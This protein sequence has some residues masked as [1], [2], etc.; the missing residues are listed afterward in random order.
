VANFLRRE[1]TTSSS[2]HP[3]GSEAA[4]KAFVDQKKRNLWVKDKDGKIQKVAA[5]L[6]SECP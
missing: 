3:P 4:Y 6:Y 1:I 5:P 2:F